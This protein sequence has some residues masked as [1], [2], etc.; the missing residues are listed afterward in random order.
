MDGVAASVARM[1][2]SS[3]VCGSKLLCSVV[4]EPSG[5]MLT[6]WLR[7]ASESPVNWRRVVETALV[8]PPH[9]VLPVSTR[10]TFPAIISW[11]VSEAV[12]MPLRTV[13]TVLPS[14][15]WR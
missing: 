7:R 9:E 8:T 1:V 4:A 10:Q 12:V 11:R 6:V 14:A 15:S 3:Q 5:A 2:V 13:A